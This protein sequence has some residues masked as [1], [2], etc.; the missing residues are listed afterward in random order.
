[1]SIHS[2]YSDEIFDSQS[3]PAELKSWWLHSELCDSGQV[4]LSSVSQFPHP[5]NGAN[6]RNCSIG[7]S[8]FSASSSI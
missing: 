1:M 6:K 4:T 7:L 2:K 5:L 3:G 8:E